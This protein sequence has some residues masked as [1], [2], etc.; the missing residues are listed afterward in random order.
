MRAEGQV[1]HK[2]AQ[3]LYRHLQKRVRDNFKR[4]HAGCR[5][6]GQ[7]RPLAEGAVPLQGYGRTLPTDIE[8]YRVCL[9]A[10]T[11]GQ[12]TKDW[13]GCCCDPR[14][15]PDQPQRCEFWQARNTKAEIKAAF[16]ASLQRPRGEVAAEYPDAVALLWVLGEEEPFPAPL[17]DP[18][19]VEP[20]PESPTQGET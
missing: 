4:T 18:D 7:P 12:D 2:L 20:L 6:N 9:Y 19:S 3:V 14:L 15:N 5:F 10:L 17:E 13:Y 1:R 8:P 11:A 16:I